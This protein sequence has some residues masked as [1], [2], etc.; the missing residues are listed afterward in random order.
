MVGGRRYAF[1]QL[2]QWNTEYKLV[3][4][5]KDI[6]GN[7]ISSTG[8][9]NVVGGEDPLKVV[10]LNIIPGWN[11]LSIPVDKSVEVAGLSNIVTVW[12]WKGDKWAVWSPDESLMEIINKY[13]SQGIVEPLE[14]INPGEGFWVNTQ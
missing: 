12:K 13:I 3:Y 5:V 9:V 7:I 2:L 10:K 11:L 1:N 4:V 6:D 8:I 14:T